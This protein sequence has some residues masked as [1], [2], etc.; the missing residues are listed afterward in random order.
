MREVQKKEYY[1]A[2]DWQKQTAEKTAHHQGRDLYIHQQYLL[3][4]RLSKMNTTA[5][6]VIASRSSFGNCN[7]HHSFKYKSCSITT[8]T[9]NTTRA[10]S[11]GCYSNG[12]RT[13]DSNSSNRPINH[14]KN[15]NKNSSTINNIICSSTTT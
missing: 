6:K 10:Q 11:G 1:L 15:I 4:N 3:D 5:I 13:T 9:T 12:T 14:Q 8:N 2:A 7:H